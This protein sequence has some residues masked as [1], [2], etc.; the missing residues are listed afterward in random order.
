VAKK[1]PEQIRSSGFVPV[2]TSR[3]ACHNSANNRQAAIRGFIRGFGLLM[4]ATPGTHVSAG[5]VKRH[6]NGEVRGGERERLGLAKARRQAQQHREVSLCALL[7][8]EPYE[9]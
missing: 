4:T 2:K 6:P 7:V 9:A 3:G 5:D 8:K 1:T